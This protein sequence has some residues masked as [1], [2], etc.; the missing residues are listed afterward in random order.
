[1]DKNADIEGG[2]ILPI[3]AQFISGIARAEA[4]VS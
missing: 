3:T 4:Q 2:H 1:M